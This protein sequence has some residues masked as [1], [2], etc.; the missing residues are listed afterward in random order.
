MVHHI[1]TDAWSRDLLLRDLFELYRCQCSGGQ[2][3]LPDIHLQYGDYALWEE[4]HYRPGS[5]AVD[6]EREF[7]RRELAGIPSPLE[8][9]A[10]R[11]RPPSPSFLGDHVTIELGHALLAALQ[12]LARRENATLFMVLHA[13][14]AGLLARMGAGTDIPIGTP[15]S[16]RPDERF[17]QVIGFFANT[18]VLRTDLS[19][20][21]S[22]RELLARVR[23]ADSAAYDHQ[24]YPFDQLV[25]DLNPLRSASIN[26]LFQVLITFEQGMAQPARVPGLSLEAIPVHLPR[27]KFDLTFG[28]TVSA[29]DEPSLIVTVEFNTDLFDAAAIWELG[30]RL[31]LLLLAVTQAPEMPVTEAKILTVNDQRII[32]DVQKGRAA[33]QPPADITGLVRA[34]AKRR[35]SAIA[36]RHEG[37]EITYDQ[38][39]RQTGGLARLLRGQGIGP[40]S[41]VAVAFPRSIDLPVA[42]LAILQA[43]AAYMPL[44]LTYPTTRI[45]AMLE[46]AR[47]A[48][49]ITRRQDLPDLPGADRYAIVDMTDPVVQ[50]HMYALPTGVPGEASRE[51][52]AVPRGRP[53]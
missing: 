40:E 20:R 45:A 12:R 18:I 13:A 11:P 14:V 7:W 36:V 5:A 29:E 46:D 44:D 24:S 4:R 19:G 15:V 17:E 43:G 26:P 28:F 3:T 53:T 1:V 33:G 9:P 21:P 25:T 22:F 31:R 52:T 32:A 2:P 6:E 41:I 27:A 37:S 8:L 30:I 49:V 50:D 51:H 48:C 39:I 10:S 38:L 23:S 35:P 34:Q 42:L 16:N 47:P